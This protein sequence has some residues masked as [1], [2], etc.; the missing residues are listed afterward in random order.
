MP[1]GQIR[2]W[3]GGPEWTG[4]GMREANW[5]MRLHQECSLTAL[6]DGGMQQPPAD[7]SCVVPHW[8]ARVARPTAN[9]SN[10]QPTSVNF[11]RSS[12]QVVVSECE[13]REM[14][15]KPQRSGYSVCRR[16][17]ELFTTRFPTHIWKVISSC[18][19]N[20]LVSGSEVVLLIRVYL[21]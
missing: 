10:G 12:G 15:A 8:S 14:W 3:S 18:C 1:I 19:V 20:C 11:L 6:K 17:Y 13:V 9:S 2:C 5:A 16:K 7:L 21:I 4:I